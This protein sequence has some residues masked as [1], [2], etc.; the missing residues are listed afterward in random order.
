MIEQM[1]RTARVMSYP[2]LALVPAL[3]A[4]LVLVPLAWWLA[5]AVRGSRA[6]AVAS[7]V[8]LSAAVTVTLARPGLRS[9]QADWGRVA[10][11]CTVTD[12]HPLTTEALLNLLL[13]APF[14]ALAVLAVGRPI[15]VALTAATISLAIEALQAAY[16]VGACDSSDVLRN[17]AGALV[18]ALLAW[19]LTVDFGPGRRERSGPPT[20]IPSAERVG[21]PQW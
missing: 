7:A 4:M 9:E 13:L 16:S 8:C 1:A 6:A 11:A 14:A 20:P 5:T 19:V 2:Q 10:S 12:P 15:R 3:M 17:S 21:S 18:A